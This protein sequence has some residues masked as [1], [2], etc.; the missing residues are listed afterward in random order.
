LASQQNAE[1][2][3]RG[4]KQKKEGFCFFSKKLGFVLWGFLN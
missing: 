1:A 2:V 4:T 3:A